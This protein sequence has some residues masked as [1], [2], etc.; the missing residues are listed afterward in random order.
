M[1]HP[2]HKMT[3]QMPEAGGDLS[4][5]AL[6][7][8][9]KSASLGGRLHPITRKALV[10]FLRLT[11]SY[12]SNLIEG[13]YS[14]PVD[15]ERA[16]ND[17]FAAEPAVRN[18]QMEARVHVEVQKIIEAKSEA[19]EI[20]VCTS[21]F[22]CLIHRLFYE[23]LPKALW[24]VRNQETGE[25]QEVIPGHFR[26]A[27][28]T[29]GR[30][31]PPGP[32]EIAGLMERFVEVYAPESHRGI[33]RLLAAAASH[34]RL[35]WI[36][37]FLDGN[38][39]VTRL[40]TGCYLIHSDMDGYG[41]WTIIRGFAR[42]RDRY[43]QHLADADAPKQADVN[44]RGHLTQRGLDR[45]C[46]FFLETCMDQITFMGTLLDIDGMVDRLRGYIELRNQKMVPGVLPIKPEAFFLLREAF[47]AGEFARGEAARIT[48]LGQRTA[49]QVLRRLTDEGLLV[50]D[51]PK[52]PVRLAFSAATSRYWFPDLISE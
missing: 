39:R 15:I 26:Q 45:F 7:V 12:Y 36:H 38:G 9:R 17:D 3:P 30:H 43:I 11:N 25:D 40:F 44:G 2:T 35:A 23:G 18:R 28:V 19:G 24:I 29:V 50:S 1:F 32:E 49:R 27:T 10:E 31:I 14:H 37:P 5:L 51:T 8:F 33:D 4:D 34:H 41:L 48:G 13:H 21:E 46:L 42:Y 6:D 20:R 16:M 52:A 22:I 47:L